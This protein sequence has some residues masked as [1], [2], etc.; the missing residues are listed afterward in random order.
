M[1]SVNRVLKKRNTAIN[2]DNETT[3]SVPLSSNTSSPVSFM[4]TKS[5]YMSQYDSLRE[6]QL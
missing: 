6:K 2:S 5:V 3:T 1:S 4:L